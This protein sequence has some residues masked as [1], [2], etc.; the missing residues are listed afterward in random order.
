MYRKF[1][2]CPRCKGKKIVDHNDTIECLDC[3]LIFEKVIIELIE[4]TVNRLKK[5]KDQKMIE[6]ILATKDKKTF[7]DALLSFNGKNNIKLEKI[8]LYCKNLLNYSDKVCSLCGT[9]AIRQFKVIKNKNYL[10][11]R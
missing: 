1:L 7:I 5:E 9:D 4:N 2:N 10:L 11:K 8:C 3:R 6:N